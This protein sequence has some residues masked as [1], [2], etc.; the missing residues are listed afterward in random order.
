MN[1][2]LSSLAA[3]AL[4]AVTVAAAPA[5]AATL[6]GKVAG[7]AGTASAGA[8][9]GHARG[10]AAGTTAASGTV[11]TFRIDSLTTD[12]QVTQLRAATDLRAFLDILSGFRAGSMTA[13]GKASV[14]INAAFEDAAGN[15]V[16][17]SASD[18]RALAGTTT[19]ASARSVGVAR[20]MPGRGEGW[21]ASTTQMVA[22]NGG[23]PVA[24][25][26]SSQA[27]ELVEVAEQ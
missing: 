26:G 4:L 14:T 12:E 7:S 18:P 6:T 22:W 8:S 27:T 2:S 23:V 1:R 21:L 25:A 13:K 24:R 16:L 17:L 10:S 5:S 3:A 20:L 15:Y 19:A 11:V 9:A